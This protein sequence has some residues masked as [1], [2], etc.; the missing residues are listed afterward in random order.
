MN[1]YY[2]VLYVNKAT[3]IF[4]VMSVSLCLKVSIFP[5]LRIQILLH[6]VHTANSNRLHNA[7]D[8]KI[9]NNNER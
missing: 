5:D 3:I 6:P 4:N 9:Q 8:I 7:N 2:I 1:K